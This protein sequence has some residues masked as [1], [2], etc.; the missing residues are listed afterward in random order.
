VFGP[1]QRQLDR[2]FN[3]AFAREFFEGVKNN[4]NFPRLDAYTTKDGELVVKLAVAGYPAENIN[5]QV[6]PDDVLEISGSA[7]SDNETAEDQYHIRELTRGSFKRQLRLPDNVAGDPKA[8]LKDGILKLRRGARAGSEA[9]SDH[10]GLTIGF[11]ED[12]MRPTRLAEPS[13]FFGLPGMFAA[14]DAAV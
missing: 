7:K 4:S 3:E 8:E 11:W 5:V 9:D 13:G 12:S 1:V 6:L 14:W 10:D 2:M